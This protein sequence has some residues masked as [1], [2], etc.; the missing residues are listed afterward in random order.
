MNPL[1]NAAQTVRLQEL[2]RLL[3]LPSV[4]SCYQKLATEAASHNSSYEA[5]LLALLEQEAGQR[6][7]N[8]RQRRLREAHFPRLYTLDTYDFT[9][10]PSLPKAK[11]L[12]LAR[13]DFLKQ[14]ANVILVGEIGTGKTHLAT[15]LGV[16]LCEQ[17]RRVRF[18]TA[19]GLI[20]ALLEAAEQHRLS[21]LEAQLLKLD[22]IILDELGFIP[23]SQQGA[24]MLFTFISQKYLQGSLLLTTNLAF[25]DWTQ[26]FGN[27]RLTAALLDRLAHRAVILEFHGQSYRFRQSLRQH[28]LPPPTPSS[29]PSPSS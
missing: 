17:G 20:T 11:V 1:A 14:A 21:R 2:L 5:Y 3:R 27:E 13:G 6:E 24:Q 9:L 28:G 15:A 26:V 22:L 12:E 8:R 29:S 25:A 4:A 23:F 16:A 19:A 10:M 7:R 18:F